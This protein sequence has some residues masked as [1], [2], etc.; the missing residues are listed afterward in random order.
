[1]TGVTG[2][3]VEGVEEKAQYTALGYSCV[4]NQD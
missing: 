4:Q 1:M 2:M 3:S